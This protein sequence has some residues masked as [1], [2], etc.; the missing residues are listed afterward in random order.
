MLADKDVRRRE[1]ST[2]N[3]IRT[4]VR[5]RPIDLVPQAGARSGTADGRETSLPS[6][7]RVEHNLEPDS[8]PPDTLIQTPSYRI[9]RVT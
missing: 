9:Q 3:R 5:N 1:E 6:I 4:G 8:S 7:G 2:N